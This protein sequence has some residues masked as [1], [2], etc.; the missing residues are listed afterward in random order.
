MK[1]SVGGRPIHCEAMGRGRTKPKVTLRPPPFAGAKNGAP[2][3]APD[4]STRTASA[5]LTTTTTATSTSST[6]PSFYGCLER[7]PKTH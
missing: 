3:R 5:V 6:S 7:L 2:S 4:R 1:T